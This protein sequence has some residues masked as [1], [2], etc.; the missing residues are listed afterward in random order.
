[1][2]KGDF[3]P[4]S[5]AS[6]LD[7]QDNNMVLDHNEKIEP[8]VPRNDDDTKF[9]IRQRMYDLQLKQELEEIDNEWN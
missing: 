7:Y 4:M 8:Y 2:K 9:R 1:M 5:A 3:A 6:K